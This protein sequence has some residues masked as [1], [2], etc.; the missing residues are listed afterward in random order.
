MPT[1]SDAELKNLPETQHALQLVGPGKLVLNSS[2]A[3]IKPTGRQILA[4]VE[5]VGL[6]FSDL[7]LLKQFSKHPRKMAV[8]SGIDQQILDGLPSYAPDNKPT[9]PGHEALVRIIAVGEDCCIFKPGQRMLIQ[10]DTRHIMTPITNIAI[11]YGME[12]GLQEYWLSDE[13]VMCDESTGEKFLIP[14]DDS[15]CASAITLVEPWACVES[16]YVSQE[17]TTIKPA[18]RLLVVA[19]AGTKIEGISGGFSPDGPPAGITTLLAEDKQEEVLSALNLP[20]TQAAD[21]AS[22]DEEGYDDIIYFGSSAKT[23]NILNDKLANSG[24][25]NIVTAGQLIGENVSVGV[26]RV[27]YGLTRWIGTTTSDAAMSYRNIPTTGE[28]RNNDRTLIVGAAGPMGQM[29][30]IRD[31]CAGIEGVSIVATDF[32]AARL[33][34][35]ETKTAAIA[36]QRQVDLKMVDP[37][38]EPIEGTFTYIALMVPIGALVAEAIIQSSQGCLINIF[39][40]IPAPTRHD[41]DLDTY[42]ARDCFMFGTSGSRVTDMLIVLD[43]VITGQLD[44]NCSVDAVCGMAGAAD[45]IGAVENRSVPGKIL[46]YPE[47]TNMGL[48]NL[49]EL[50][51]HYPTVAEKLSDGLW[52]IEAEKELLSA[53]KA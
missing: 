49:D 7:K 15:Q 8:V 37:R 16:S 36:T 5:A 32:D 50:V 33:D 44:T 6:C 3:V 34:A 25:I 52:T 14:V 39:A 48:I 19:D 45:G 46:V 2:K 43:K 12:G 35:L 21:L 30:V 17:R 23:L 26:G 31:V 40:G 18:G 42:I 4:K 20:V 47:L 29:H 9:V 38:S 22:L 10:A 53:A 51:D 27:H 13:R 28:L 11:G 1:T 41:L 24:I